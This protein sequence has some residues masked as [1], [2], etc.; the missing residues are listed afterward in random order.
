MG[1]KM[2]NLIKNYKQV[3][4]K[5]KK[6]VSLEKVKKEEP[7][8]YTTF[9]FPIEHYSLGEGKKHIILEAGVHGCEIITVD[10][11]LQLME[12]M[13]NGKDDKKWNTKEYKFHFFPLMNPEGYI[14][15][16]SA[17]QAL[18]PK[19]ADFMTLE[20]FVKIIILNI[21]KMI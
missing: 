2:E 4:E 3:Q 10:F 13:S 1:D 17:I 15:S 12:E 11:L 18:F 8:G 6:I 21:G 20:K 5:L 7:I 16:T 9:G 19:D 14:I